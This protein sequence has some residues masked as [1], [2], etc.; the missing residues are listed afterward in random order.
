[1]TRSPSKDFL[2]A[3][4]YE[5]PKLDA[6]WNT[7]THTWELIRWAPDQDRP[8]HDLAHV[9][10]IWPHPDLAIEPIRAALQESDV[11]KRGGFIH[12][13]RDVLKPRLIRQADERRKAYA[14]QAAEGRRVLADALARDLG[15]RTTVSLARTSPQG[16]ILP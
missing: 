4:R 2:K 15:K 5:D 1:M 3:L 10:L 11:W 9:I 6:R 12:Y 16:I 8:G 7:A 13:W 14:T